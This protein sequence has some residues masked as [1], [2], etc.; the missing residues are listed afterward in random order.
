MPSWARL[1]QLRSSIMHDPEQAIGLVRDQLARG[2]ID[3]GSRV[4]LLILLAETCQWRGRVRDAVT[5]I[6]AAAEVCA[7]LSD[8]DPRR[9]LLLGIGAD[10]AV[11]DCHAGAVQAST[12]YVT[13]AVHETQ[14]QLIRV[15]VAGA[16]R[17]SAVYH[18][19]DCTEGRRILATLLQR[20]PDSGPATAM[21]RAGI[22][23]MRDG[24]RPFCQ[25]APVDPA[26]PMPGGVLC[27][28]LDW[29]HE[30]YIASR[31]RRHPAAHTCGFAGAQ[32]AGDLPRPNV[33]GH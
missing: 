23:A 2:G 27:L 20:L 21:V 15:V 3:A 18:L 32:R 29:L 22:V 19:T 4:E 14:P 16:L 17:A 6:S 30:D 1:V 5:A 10:L 13:A 33:D 12:A 26:P 9:T 24:C 8:T 28:A 25:L 31:V 11:W 7:P